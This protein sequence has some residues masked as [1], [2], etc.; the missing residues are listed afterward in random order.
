MD[1]A[2]EVREFLNKQFPMLT[3][4]GISYNE[5]L[6]SFDVTYL[7]IAAYYTPS[8]VESQTAAVF[9]STRNLLNWTTVLQPTVNT[10]RLWFPPT[11][12]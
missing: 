4:V 10:L 5:K 9:R 7:P 8:Q 3:I 11:I 1:I 12:K 6:H 2:L